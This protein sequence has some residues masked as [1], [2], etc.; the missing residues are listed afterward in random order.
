ESGVMPHGQGAP[1]RV[2]RE[3]GLEPLLLGGSGPGG[4]VAV[5]AVQHHD[6]PG[7][8]VV[9]VIAL[10]GVA[11]G[12]PEIAE[13]AV[14]RGARVV[15]TVARRG[16]GARLVPPPTR[17]VTRLVPGRSSVG[18]RVVAQREYGA[19]DRVEQ[20]GG[21]GRAGR[22]TAGDVACANEDHPCG[23]RDVDAHRPGGH[24]AALIVRAGSAEDH[25]DGLDGGTTP[26]G[27][28]HGRWCSRAAGEPGK[29]PSAAAA[30]RVAPARGVGCRARATE[31][32]AAIARRAWR[33]GI[34][35][36]WFVGL[37]LA[38]RNGASPETRRSVASVAVSP[39]SVLVAVGQ[40]VQLSAVP[41]DA[42]G[43]PVAG[44]VVPWTTGDS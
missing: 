36:A 26:E 6:V 32:V 34:A 15:V 5:I 42:H 40:S 23:R 22:A 14:A 10:V 41:L 33:L 31:A 7:A 38:C 39:R 29:Y 13:V 17:V 35:T 37:A 2:G 1:P 24:A 44:R 3:V 20:G 28:R 12:G 4:D 43:T 8:Q 27:H 18:V 16:K 21:G 19:R 9:A 11:G 30:S 25:H